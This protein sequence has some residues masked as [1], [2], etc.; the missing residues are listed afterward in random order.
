MRLKD[1][2]EQHRQF[3]DRETIKQWLKKQHIKSFEINRDLTV[4]VTS[5]AVLSSVGPR[6]PVQFGRVS[7]NFDVSLGHLVSLEGSPTWVGKSFSCAYNPDLYSL[8][9]APAFV[10]HDFSCR[11]TNI[12]SLQNIHK[13]V[14][15]IGG[16]LIIGDIYSHILGV[17]LIRRLRFVDL[18]VKMLPPVGLRQAISIINKHLGGDRN[19]HDAQEELIEAGLKEYAKL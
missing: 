13:Q 3:Q 12:T 14:K 6:L 10:G 17:L 19:I 5:N 1:L 18:S 16:K 11:E 7:G 4:D 8:E 9:Y 2:F 15:D